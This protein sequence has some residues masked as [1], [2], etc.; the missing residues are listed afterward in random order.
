MRLA[1]QTFYNK[2]TRHKRKGGTR[3]RFLFSSSSSSS[4]SS[5]E[6]FKTT[7]VITSRIAAAAIEELELLHTRIQSQRSNDDNRRETQRARHTLYCLQVGHRVPTPP[8]PPHLIMVGLTPLA[9]HGSVG[10]RSLTR[11]GMSCGG[12]SSEYVIR[13]LGLQGITCFLGLRVFYNLSLYQFADLR[14]VSKRTD[15]DRPL[16]TMLSAL[17]KQ[18]PRTVNHPPIK[19]PRA[20]SEEDPWTD[21]LCNLV[22][23]Q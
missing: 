4:T 3:T 9:I 23:R 22:D 15:L 17:T 5:L 7:A 16:P 2:H 14:T 8:P 13:P 1:Q 11:R 18:V 19:P 12:W 20:V 6:L 10:G 21:V